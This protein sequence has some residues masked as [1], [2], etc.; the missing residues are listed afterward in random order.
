MKPGV[1]GRDKCCLSR[2]V[3]SR[4]WAEKI[5]HEVV[6]PDRDVKFLSEAIIFHCLVVDVLRDE[7]RLASYRSALS[8]VVKS[9][10][11]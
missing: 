4:D 9:G 2:R 10:P 11:V 5:P 8:V 6:V 3:N 1:A 7:L